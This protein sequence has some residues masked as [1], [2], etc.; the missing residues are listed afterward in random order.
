M[1]YSKESDDLAVAR[2]L[3]SVLGVKLETAKDASAMVYVCFP[4]ADGYRVG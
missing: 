1:H 2:D 3:F 4:A